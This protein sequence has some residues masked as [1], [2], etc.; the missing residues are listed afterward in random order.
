MTS[1]A[2]VGS[3]YLLLHDP[4]YREVRHEHLVET[5]RRIRLKKNLGRL[6]GLL[7]RGIGGCRF[8]FY[9][10]SAAPE[11][12]VQS[13]LAG[14]V[15][16]ERIRA[17]RFNYDPQTGEIQS[18]R[19]VSAGYGKVAALGAAIAAPGEPR[20]R[21]LRGPDSAGRGSPPPPRDQDSEHP[22]GRPVS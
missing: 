3:A 11:E 5:G 6:V 2:F 1:K 14:I 13:A 10:L 20:P 15:G 17:T 19:H 16:P 9:A 21:R 12:V 8:E 22:G 4:E 7:E 18:I